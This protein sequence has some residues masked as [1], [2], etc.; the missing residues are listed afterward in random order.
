MVGCGNWGE[1]E[2]ASK[3]TTSFLSGAT[4]EMMKLFTKMGT[5]LRKE[6]FEGRRENLW[7]QFERNLK[8]KK[9][10]TWVWILRLIWKISAYSLRYV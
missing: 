2:E 5:C 1:G 7:V 3:M 4:G 10:D 8:L 6:Q 9:L